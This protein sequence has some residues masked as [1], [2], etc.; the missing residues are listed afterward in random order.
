M[1]QEVIDYVRREFTVPEIDGEACVHALVQTATCRACVDACP[2][3]AWSLDEGSLEFD[4][5][6][7]DGCGLCVP[8]C[9]QGVIQHD[10]EPLRRR[11]KARTLAFLACEYAPPPA[12]GQVMPCL[13]A[14]GP[15]DLLALYRDGYQ[16]LV[17]PVVDCDACPRGGGVRLEDT[18]AQI[19]RMLASRAL[20]EMRVRVVSAQKWQEMLARTEG[21]VEGPR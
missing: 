19:N 21:P 5:A 15:G 10:Y 20:P 2:R 16:Y 17:Q 6:R 11:W 12:S 8:A 14:L 1:L 18:L 7:C 9:P 3:G 4:T 13:H